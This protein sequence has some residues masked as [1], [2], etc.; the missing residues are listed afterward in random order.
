MTDCLRA[1]PRLYPSSAS[2]LSRII[3]L[4]V[5]AMDR[6]QSFGD[7]VAIGGLNIFHFFISASMVQVMSLNCRITSLRWFS[8][9]VSAC[10]N[11]LVSSF[12]GLLLGCAF[13]FWSKFMCAISEFEKIANAFS[14]ISTS[15]F[16]ITSET[17]SSER[18][19]SF[20]A[21]CILSAWWSSFV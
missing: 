17:N 20:R 3:V 5:R 1:Y 15:T 14:S 4:S 12:F 7:E 16:F 2:I 8:R 11:S 10:I 21:R 19:D 6:R 9:M 18:T 13:S